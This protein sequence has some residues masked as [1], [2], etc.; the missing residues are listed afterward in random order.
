MK[1]LIITVV[2]LLTIMGAA[3]QTKSAMNEN[4][5]PAI[6][7]VATGKKV[8]KNNG[9]PTGRTYKGYPVYKGAKGGMFVI[10]VSKKTGNEYKQYV[11]D[12]QLDGNRVEKVSAQHSYQ[13]PRISK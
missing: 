2:A 7:Q 3:S 8:V 6:E 9:T 4:G 10:R 1:K 11:K 12:E 5:K 13:V